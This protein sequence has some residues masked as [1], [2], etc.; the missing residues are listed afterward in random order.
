VAEVSNLHF[1][2]PAKNLG[3]HERIRLTQGHLGCAIDEKSE[4]ER[5]SGDGLEVEGEL[6]DRELNFYFANVQCSLY[7]A[8]RQQRDQV[9]R[10]K[11]TFSEIRLRSMPR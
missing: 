5:D 10:L 3:Q 11:R 9:E 4:T 1:R 8:G 6:G 2:G 7:P